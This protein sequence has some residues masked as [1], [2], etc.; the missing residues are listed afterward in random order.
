MN[1]E[2]VSANVWIQEYVG[3]EGLTLDAFRQDFET[4]RPVYRA[5]NGISDRQA[6]LDE[7]SRIQWESSARRQASGEALLTVDADEL[8]SWLAEE[9]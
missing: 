6:W 8:A 7:Y 9:E 4:L 5:M 2:R 3:F 1:T